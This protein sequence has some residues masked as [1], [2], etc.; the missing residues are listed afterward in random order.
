MKGNKRQKAI[1][2]KDQLVGAHRAYS[3]GKSRLVEQSITRIESRRDK[4]IPLPFFAILLALWIIAIFSPLTVDSDID[5]KAVL[6]AITIF[7]F[8]SYFAFF[9]VSKIVVKP[10]VEEFEDDTS[11]LALFSACE[12][13]ERRGLLSAI[14]GVAHTIV[15]GLYI[16]LKHIGVDAW[17]LF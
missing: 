9:H 14:F 3:E 16:I 2:I 1:D 7:F 15:F 11:Y 17:R 6:T 8:I 4:W 5:V 10:T 13:R 12:S